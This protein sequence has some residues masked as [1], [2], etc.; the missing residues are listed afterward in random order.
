[1]PTTDAMLSVPQRERNLHKKTFQA[2]GPSPDKP[3]QQ[4]SILC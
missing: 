4:N 3:D 2:L 1:M